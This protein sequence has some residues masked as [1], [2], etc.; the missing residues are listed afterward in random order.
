MRVAVHFFFW[1]L[2][3]V[4]RIDGRRGKIYRYKNEKSYSIYSVD[5]YL[6]ARIIDYCRVVGFTRYL[7][8]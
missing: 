1:N 5:G 4:T 8:T 3:K 7:G 6:H 2:F